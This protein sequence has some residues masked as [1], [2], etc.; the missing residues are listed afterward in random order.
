MHHKLF[1]DL[2]LP[3]SDGGAYI[4]LTDPLAG[5]RVWDPRK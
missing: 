1:G 5:L 3:G 2:A 4:A